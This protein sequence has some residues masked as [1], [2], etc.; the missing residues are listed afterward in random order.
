MTTA[1]QQGDFWV[2]WKVRLVVR[3]E[4]YGDTTSVRNLASNPITPPQVMRGVSNTRSQALAVQN[5]PATPSSPAGYTINFQGSTAT[6]GSGPQDVNSSQDGKTFVLGACVPKSFGW[7]VNG[8]KEPDTFEC[9]LPYVDIPF[10]PLCFRSVALEF[11]CGA[12]DPDDYQAGVGGATRQ[13]TVGGTPGS[14]PMNVIPDT[15]TGPLGEARSNSRFQGFVDEWEQDWNDNG[16]AMVRLKCTDNTRLFMDQPMPPGL[17]LDGTKPIDQAIAQL[18]A[19]FPQFAGLTV[20]YQP[21]GVT[22]P[23]LGPVFADSAQMPDGLSPTQGGAKQTLSVWDYLVEMATCVGHNIRVEGTT[24]VIQRVRAAV[25]RAFPPRYNDPFQGRSWGGTSHPL[26]TFIWGRNAKKAGRIKRMTRATVN[27]EV[28]SFNPLTKTTMISRFPPFANSKG[29]GGQASG[30][31][32]STNRLVHS[33]PGDGRQETKYTVFPVPGVADQA[34]L[35]VIAQAYYEGLNRAECGVRITT[36]DLASFA[37]DNT[38][39]DVLDMFAGDKFEYLIEKFD[40]STGDVSDVGSS[41]AVLENALLQAGAAYSALVDQG[42]DPAF[43]TA[44]A[45]TYAAVGYQTVFVL[46]KM[47]VQGSIDEGITTMLEGANAIEARVDA[48]GVADYADPALLAG[49]TSSPSA[50][51]QPGGP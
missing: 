49:G 30:P 29:I 16:I 12:M 37:G 31:N 46:R 47:D 7:H 8:F 50:A 44:Y 26:R 45:Q 15:F 2:G 11:F 10:D 21:A 13:T 41:L 3:L 4:E 19:N 22:P 9:E 14:E 48:P 27:V 34:T 38:D 25:G 42:Y 43:A 36:R 51:G 24:L 28:R 20:T 33:L 5:T 32:A 17:R 23:T 35:Q 18:L 39:P 6:S 40:G 1:V